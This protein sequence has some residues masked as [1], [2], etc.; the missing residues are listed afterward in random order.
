MTLNIKN[1]N[2]FYIILISFLIVSPKWIYSIIQFHNEDFLLKSLYLTSDFYYYPLI[3]NISELDLSPLYLDIE[4]NKLGLL[5][6]PILNL[7]LISIFFKI[8]GHYAF[9]ILEFICIIFVLIIFD[10]LFKYLKFSKN[11]SLTY[12]LILLS[13]PF[14]FQSLNYLNFPFTEKIILN[15]STFY[16]LRF[17]RPIITNLF[18]FYFIFISVKIYNYNDYNKNNYL[19]TGILSGLSLHLFFYF[20]IIQNIFFTFLHIIKFKKN[21]LKFLFEK[22]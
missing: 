8:F 11:L 7:G 2:L 9:L 19:I 6:F 21:I 13:T 1:K 16:D 3:S 10:T 20:F 18:L 4:I 17:P 5:S 14:L 15:Y 12:S 22:K